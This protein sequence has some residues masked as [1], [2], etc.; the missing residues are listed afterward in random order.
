MSTD[1]HYG[2]GHYGK[3]QML[4]MRES[5]VNRSCEMLAKKDIDFNGT[6]NGAIILE[7]LYAPTITQNLA[8][9]VRAEEV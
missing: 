1:D 8:R 4:V 7:A 2:K 6:A 3:G 5:A 9:L